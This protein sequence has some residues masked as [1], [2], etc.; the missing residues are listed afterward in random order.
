M[1]PLNILV[2]VP[3]W[4]GDLIMSL[5]FFDAIH[6]ALP[7]SRIDIIAKDAVHDIFRHHPAITKIH[8]FSKA[9]TKGLRRL[10][11]YGRALKRETVFDVFL[12]LH[13]C[14]RQV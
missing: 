13:H 2:R 1:T 7:Y 3:N 14:F 10:F 8:S 6:L 9:K 4:V 11:R 12:R 5:P